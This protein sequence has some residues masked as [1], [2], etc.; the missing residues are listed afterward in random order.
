MQGFKFA[1]RLAL[2]HAGKQESLRVCIPSCKK[3]GKHEAWRS[4]IHARQKDRLQ[5]IFPASFLAG[6]QDGSKSFT[7]K[8][9]LSTAKGRRLTPKVARHDTT[10]AKQQGGQDGCLDLPFTVK[11]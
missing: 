1:G 6:L 9:V 11:K 4:I 8:S 7:V 10:S 3:D 2:H 5:A